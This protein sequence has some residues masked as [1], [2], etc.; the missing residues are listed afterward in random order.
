MIMSLASPSISPSSPRRAPL[1]PRRLDGTVGGGKH[2]SSEVQEEKDGHGVQEEQQQ[3]YKTH[4]KMKLNTIAD[5]FGV[6]LYY[7]SHFIRA[8]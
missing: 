3:F 7:Y 8:G 2:T 1:R 5:H 4:R 6:D